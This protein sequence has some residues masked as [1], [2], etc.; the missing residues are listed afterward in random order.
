MLKLPNDREYNIRHRPI[1]FNTT[2][3]EH[4]TK[5]W[6][7]WRWVLTF[8][9]ATTSTLDDYEAAVVD[10]T[11]VLA[12]RQ[13]GKPVQYLSKKTGVVRT[14]VKK[15]EETTDIINDALEL[16][17]QANASHTGEGQTPP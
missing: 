9:T 12:H 15:H 16:L 7:G 17:R 5:E 1:I 14:R 3:T 13:A 6:I 2:E 10:G 8:Y 4:Y 11:W